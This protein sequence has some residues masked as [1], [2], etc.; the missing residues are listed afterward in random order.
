MVGL[1]DETDL[2]GCTTHYTR[3]GP[4][5]IAQ[6]RVYISFR[7]AALLAIYRHVQKNAPLFEIPT[8]ILPGKMAS[9]C[10]AN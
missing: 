4:K 3:S 8:S 5:C 7:V 2:L 6:K 10:K 9:Q 1:R